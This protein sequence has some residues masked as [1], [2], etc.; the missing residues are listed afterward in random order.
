M[1]IKNT[2]ITSLNSL[3][4]QLYTSKEFKPLKYKLANYVYKRLA[5]YSYIGYIPSQYLL[6]LI[7]YPSRQEH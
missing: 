4:V 3:L 6:F 2:N 7:R 5:S 1:T